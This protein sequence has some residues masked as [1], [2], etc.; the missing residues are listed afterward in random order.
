MHYNLEDF[1]TVKK[2]DAHVHINGHFTSFM[3]QAMRDQFYLL[4]INTEVPGY[5]VLAKQ[6]SHIHQLSKDF[7]GQVGYLT[8]FSTEHLHSD[9]WEEKALAYLKASFE[10][11]AAGMKVWKN[12]GMTLQDNNGK[13]IMIDDPLFDPIFDFVED[14]NITV[15]GHIGEPKNCWLPLEE[16]TVN[17][18]RNYYKEHPEY[19]MYLH[20]QYPTYEELIQSR[21]NLLV[22][23]PGLKYIGAHLG[24]MEWSIDEVA[25]RLEKFPNMAVDLTDRICH[26]QYQSITNWQKVYDFF[27]RYQDR[28]IY[29]TDLEPQ[30]N[31]APQEVMNSAH[32]VW[33]M[34]WQYFAT[35]ETMSTPAV[36]G[37]FAGLNL[38]KGVI[39]KIYYSNAKS[40]YQLK[41]DF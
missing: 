35:N 28:I 38:P 3:N 13:F 17:N 23:R 40:W 16:M 33:M 6:Q 12:I 2:I 30:T 5:P 15:L 18:D 9:N 10:Q 36:N 1:Y 29:G 32:E 37:S 20:P 26:L 25:K 22:K 7:Q 21:D 27:V 31:L 8:S 24:S 19:H 41:I 34:D 39:D 11:S 14:N 4:S